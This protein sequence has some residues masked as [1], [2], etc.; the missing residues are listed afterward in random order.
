M[1]LLLSIPTHGTLALL[2][3]TKEGIVVCADRMEWNRVEGAKDADKIFA[4]NDEVGFVVVGAAGLSVPN[5]GTL[6]PVF[7]LSECVK[8]FYT[9][10]HFRDNASDWSELTHFLKKSFETAYRENNATIET[11]PGAVDDVV[12]EVDFLYSTG[13]SPAVKQIL[14]RLGGQTRVTSL[15]ETP[16]IAGQTAVA[17]RIL[18]P[19]QLSDNRFSDLRGDANIA[20]A[21]RS[22]APGY[23]R[24]VTVEDALILGY[25]F[26]RA[27]AERMQFI[28]N[29]P[30]LVGPICDC[31]IVRKGSGFRWLH[32]MVDTRTSVLALP[33]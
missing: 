5:L 19:T 15:S 23:P 28:S 21:W 20:R 11:S 18:R 14:Y 10:H 3:P 2:L 24:D 32:R 30:N 4:L 13:R 29:D 22:S 12:W 9:Q 31:A 16:Y 1:L 27:S 26:I 6:K 25:T 33:H 17:L 7:S 8:K